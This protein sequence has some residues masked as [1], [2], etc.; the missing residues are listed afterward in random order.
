MEK[1]MKGKG[2]GT[3]CVHAGHKHDKNAAAHTVPIYQN[4]TYV[5]ESA[6]QGAARFSGKEEGFKYTRIRPCSPTHVE[7]TKKLAALE[8]AEDKANNN[9]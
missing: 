9:G 5:F 6:E 2:F 3:K 1:D 4:S 7:F 8:G